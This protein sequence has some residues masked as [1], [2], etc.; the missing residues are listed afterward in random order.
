MEY[1]QFRVQAFEREPGK[2]RA[3]IRRGDGKP[4]KIVGR[5]KLEKFVTKF[6]A[7]TAGAAIVMAMAVIDAGMLVRDRVPTEKSGVVDAILRGPN[8]H[9]TY[10]PS[11]ATQLSRPGWAAKNVR[12]IRES[13]AEVRRRRSR[14]TGAAR[15]LIHLGMMRR[16]RKFADEARRYLLSAFLLARAQMQS[17][18]G[19]AL[20]FNRQAPS[21]G[22]HLGRKTG[23]INHLSRRLTIR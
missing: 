23:S 17:P 13:L 8:K 5:E 9:S 10:R 7:C 6:D 12:G 11:R 22:S 14:P 3:D 15:G 20:G 18:V 2:W 1:K 4:V 21:P 19:S 16:L